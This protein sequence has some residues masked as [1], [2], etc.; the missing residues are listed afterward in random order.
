MISSLVVA[1]ASTLAALQSV[2]VGEIEVEVPCQARIWLADAK[3]EIRDM[4]AEMLRSEGGGPEAAAHA[5][6]KLLATLDAEGIAIGD[7][8]QGGG[9]YGWL[10]SVDVTTP[11]GHPELIAVEPSLSIPYDT[12]S[13]LYLFRYDRGWHL[14]YQREENDYDRIGLALGSF[15]WEISP[16]DREG[17]FLILTTTVSP[18]PASVWQ[19]LTWTVDRIVPWSDEP[20]AIDRQTAVVN[21]GGESWKLRASPNG[22]GLTFDSEGIEPGFTRVRT[23]QY[24]LEGDRP[25]RV[26]PVA[27][28][29]GDFMVEW[30]DMSDE[31]AARWTD[32]GPAEVA[33]RRKDIAEWREDEDSVLSWEPAQ[34]CVD[35]L[36]QVRLDEQENVASDQY[37]P[38]YFVVSEDHGMFRLREIRDEARPGCPE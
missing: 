7:V 23:L 9:P 12:D 6:E 29:P 5:Q 30:L 21:I 10:V 24:A 22:Y 19:G 8:P 37:V 33:C 13:A 1:L 3:H 35:G 38:T 31:E 28:S 16:S 11:P 36:W 14:I 27:Q 34:R 15:G 25:V 26:D 32:V 2:H 18:S 17:R 4:A 20:I